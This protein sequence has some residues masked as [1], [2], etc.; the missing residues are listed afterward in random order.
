MIQSID[1]KISGD[2]WYILELKIEINISPFYYRFR[3]VAF[4][5]YIVDVLVDLCDGAVMTSLDGILTTLAYVSHYFRR[6]NSDNS[7]TSWHSF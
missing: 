6:Q 4:Q 7:K 1:G 3:V 2:C 5:I